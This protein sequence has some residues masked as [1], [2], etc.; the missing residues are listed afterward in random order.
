MRLRELYESAGKDIFDPKIPFDRRIEYLN[1]TMTNIG[2]GATRT[3][4]NS[5]GVALKV[6]SN[7]YGI[8]QNKSEYEFL[9][10]PGIKES[11][12]FIGVIGADTE[13]F[14]WIK[15]ELAKRITPKDFTGIAG[16]RASKLMDLVDIYRR[17]L[18]INYMKKFQ[19]GPNY[20]SEFVRRVFDFFAKNK[21]IN[22]KE[23]RS[24]VNWGIVD[25]TPVIIDAGM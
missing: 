20:D 11:G 3:V 17:V 6:A 5:D 9:S 19:P 21:D 15:T 1:S 23:Y 12:L 2:S 22:V 10:K 18:D 16:V 7:E 24:D 4:Y 13:N 8:K 14:I 25:T